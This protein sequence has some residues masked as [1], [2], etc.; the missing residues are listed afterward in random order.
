M[1]N[2]NEACFGSIPHN[3]FTGNLF[4]ENKA[5]LPFFIIYSLSVNNFNE[6]G[7]KY[8]A[9]ININFFPILF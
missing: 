7:R 6:D 5:R 4:A 1:I 9:M 2:E 8:E 3:F